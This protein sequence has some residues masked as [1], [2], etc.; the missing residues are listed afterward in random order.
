VY[1]E[2]D[3]TMVDAIARET[4]IKKRQRKWKLALI[5]RGNPT[6]RDLYASIAL[7]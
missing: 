5:E 3:E 7:V 4:R 2:L 6:W 1:Y